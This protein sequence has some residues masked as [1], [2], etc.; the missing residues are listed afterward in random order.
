MFPS[1]SHFPLHCDHATCHSQNYH[2]GGLPVPCATPHLGCGVGNIS[3]IPYTDHVESQ[4][5]QGNINRSPY[6]YQ[7]NPAEE[8]AKYAYDQDKTLTLLKFKGTSG[9]RG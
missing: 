7:A 1:L 5:P 8:R 9:D 4:I 3:V 6:A 2:A